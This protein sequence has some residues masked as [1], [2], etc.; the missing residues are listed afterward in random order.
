[1]A[2]EL[3]DN[4]LQYSNPCVELPDFWDL[5]LCLELRYQDIR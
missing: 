3:L 1:M 2:H 5:W 4:T